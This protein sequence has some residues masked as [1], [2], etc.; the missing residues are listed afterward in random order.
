MISTEQEDFWKNEFG[1]N[2]TDRNNED[3][4]KNNINFFEKILKNIS[5]NSI[6]EIGC[7]RGLNLKAIKEINNNILLNGLE[8][9]KYAYDILKELNICDKLYNDTIFNFTP[10]PL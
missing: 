8:I 9:N 5:V 10:F 4:I 7:N 3:L 1:D 2:Y 6:F